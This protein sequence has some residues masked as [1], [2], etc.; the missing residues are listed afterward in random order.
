LQDLVARGAAETVLWWDS[1]KYL[2]QESKV[3][4]WLGVGPGKVGRNLIGKSIGYD[5]KGAAAKTGGV[6][7]ITDPK[8][9]DEVLRALDDTEHVEMEV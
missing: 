8:E 4:R 1:I 6:W 3:R 9:V 5:Y 2:D 7:S